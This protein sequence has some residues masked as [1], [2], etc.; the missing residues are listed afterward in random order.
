[1]RKSVLR[2]LLVSLVLI[3]NACANLTSTESTE[4]FISAHKIYAQKLE[5]ENELAAALNQWHIVQTIVP[6]DQDTKDRIV[7]LEQK[8]KPKAQAWFSKGKSALARGQLRRAELYFLKTL[9]LQ[10]HHQQAFDKL[11]KIKTSRMLAAQD[12]KN[13]AT[14]DAYRR[15]Q[16]NIAPNKSLNLDKLRLLVK[17]QEYV[18]ASQLAKGFSIDEVNQETLTLLHE[19]DFQLTKQYLKKKDLSRSAYHFDRLLVNQSSASNHSQELESLKL[20]LA[21]AHYARAKKLFNSNLEK[22]IN[23]LETALQYNPQH[24]QAHILLAQATRMQENLLR[25]ENLRKGKK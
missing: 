17:Q 10:P 19:I 2:L 23:N 12:N 4:E 9:A 5:T 14:N 16:K 8:I 13:T 6:D 1:M 20:E 11:S 25:I 21:D 24:P 3:L 18:K 7:A 22:T 15:K